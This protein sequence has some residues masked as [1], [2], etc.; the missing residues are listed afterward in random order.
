[1]LPPFPLLLIAALY[2]KLHRCALIADMHTG[3][4]NDPRWKWSLPL[5]LRLLRGRTAV[6][7]NSF[8]ANL[9]EDKGVRAVVLHDVIEVCGAGE[10]HFQGNAVLCPVSY[11]NDEPIEEIMEAARLTPELEWIL[12]G[13]APRNVQMSA[14]TNVTFT[15]FVSDDS[16]VQRMEEAGVVLALTTRPHTMQRAG[17]EALSFGVPQ[18]T[19]D[20]PVLREFLSEAASYTDLTGTEIARSVKNV[21]ERRSEI[22]SAV[23]RI[24]EERMAEQ[25]NQ[26]KRLA[27]SIEDGSRI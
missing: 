26:L 12:T 19:S 16:F 17:Y 18:V 10:R 20:F 6:V 4:F 3:A 25:Q 1:M 9:C 2:A 22:T 13:N 14:P 24:R 8:L 21:L 7:T 11:A 15:G 23:V 27:A 5:T